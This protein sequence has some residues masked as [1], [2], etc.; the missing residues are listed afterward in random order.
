MLIVTSVAVISKLMLK[1]EI[2]R[3][4]VRMREVRYFI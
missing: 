2:T 3:A 1:P 4:Y